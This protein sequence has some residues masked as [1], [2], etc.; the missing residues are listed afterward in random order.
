MKSDCDKT[1]HYFK[2]RGFDEVCAHCGRV[3]SER[4]VI[5]PCRRTAGRD[6]ER[7]VG[8]AYETGYRLEYLVRCR[9]CGEHWIVFE[10]ADDRAE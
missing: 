1:G 8:I 6:A 10:S 9:W 7:T 3:A 4:T 2:V 5:C